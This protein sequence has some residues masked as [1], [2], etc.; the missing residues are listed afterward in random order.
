VNETDLE[1]L[2][3]TDLIRRAHAHGLL[4]HT[5]TFRN[6]Q[7]RLP[8][9]YQGNPVNEYLQF[10]QLGIDGVFSD[11][12]DSAVVA[13]TLFNLLRNRDFAECLTGQTHGRDC[14]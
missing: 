11:M 3:P 8:A 10:Y 5:W 9:D 1:R 14:H 13:R 12:S 7:R 4:V 6:E 2:P